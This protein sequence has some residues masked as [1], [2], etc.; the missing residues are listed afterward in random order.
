VKV[1]VVHEWLATWGGSE[2]V[3][4]R[5]LHAFPQAD[6]FSL[7]DFL[8][9]EYRGFVLGKQA[10][11]SFIQKLPKSKTKFRSYLPLMPIAV[12]QFDLS[13]Y[14]L[15]ISNSHAAAKGVLTGPNQLHLTYIHSP[16]RYAWDLQAQYLAEANL[17]KGLR[18]ALARTIL[19]YIRQWDTRTASSPD[20]II[21]NSRYISRRVRKVYG[22]D[23]T[24]I[25]PPVEVERFVPSGR[26]DGF[27]FTA[28]RLVPYKKI[29]LI[30]EAFAGMPHAK[31]VVIGDGPEM[32]KLKAAAG[33]NVEV[34]GYQ[35]DAA[36]L[37]HMQRCD[38]FIYAAEEDFGIVP[39]EAQACGKPVIA[40]GRGG[41]LETVNGL[42][43]A[44]PTGLFF[45]RQ[46]A[47][48]IADAVRQF[49]MLRAERP[50]LFSPE[51]C[52]ANALRFGTE[53]FDKEF[54]AFVDAEIDRF[55]GWSHEAA[56]ALNAAA[57][58]AHPPESA[59]AA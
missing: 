20:R 5:I 34:L 2:K 6:L 18:S 9:D 15:V 25:Y 35:S 59:N 39:V 50:S 44:D 53:R 30:A 28:S 54:R 3:L 46:T 8:P 23:S 52:R 11:T 27:Y 49:E 1:A 57:L 41:A 32:A 21:T 42:D 47:E 29:P 17:T 38:A 24:V 31:L 37:D 33:S 14:D 16:I 56:Q 7:V 58:T 12:E 4:S 26:S 48:S 19:H 10:R 36:F 55:E 40:Y 51:A 22:R 13:S 45:W 43:R